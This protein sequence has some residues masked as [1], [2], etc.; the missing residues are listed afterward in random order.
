MAFA[1]TFAKYMAQ[2][3]EEQHTLVNKLTLCTKNSSSSS[4]SI[5]SSRFRQMVYFIYPVT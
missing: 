4:S 3:I 5:R 2:S 1:G